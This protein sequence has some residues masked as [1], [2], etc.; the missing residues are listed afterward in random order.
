M[1]SFRRRGNSQLTLPRLLLAATILHLTLVL[2]IF[3]VGRLGI[4]PNTFDAHG[5]GVSFAI[6]SK[7]YR[8]E[9][10]KLADSLQKG[11][12][13]AWFS[14]PRLH[15]KLY[16]LHFLGMKRFVGANILSA[17][18][19]NLTCF[20]TILILVYRLG[21]EMFDQKVG[22]LAAGAVALWPSFLLHSTQM[23]RDPLFIVAFLLLVLIF[24]ILLNR[25]LSITHGVAAGVVG[26]ITCLFLWLIRGDWWELIF[27]VLLLGFAANLLKQILQ[28]RLKIINLLTA[29]LIVMCGWLLPQ[30]V[31]APRQSEAVI[32]QSVARE[33]QAMPVMQ[34]RVQVI[35]GGNLWSRA[36]RR[37]SMLR[38]K[39]ITRYPKAG[40]NIDTHVE[41]N[42]LTDIVRYF[43][44]ATVI[45]LFSPFPNMWFSRGVQVGV[46]GRL[47][48][49]AETLG[50]Y[51]IQGLAL[52]GAFFNRRRLSVWLILAIV[53][54]AATALG[55]IVVNI[56]TIYRMRYGFTMLLIVLGAKGLIEIH[57]RWKPAIRNDPANVRSPDYR[58][59][60]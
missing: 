24:V 48:A 46:A 8:V 54:T 45:G 53:L 56:S 21:D 4:F 17:E 33:T 44:R 9:A 20:L 6:D 39:F 23:L 30:I 10:A 13:A 52:V 2:G 3:L 55:Y 25:S 28:R 29:L 16:S 26:S 34:S 14:H 38:H 1:Y 18:P 51:L 11:D 27:V 19:L 47:L 60:G 50:L 31:P 12:L 5:I 7:S 22:L 49:G 43:P 41:L 59:L 42:G 57:S 36:P 35:E 40:S 37:L 58:K 32:R 15:I